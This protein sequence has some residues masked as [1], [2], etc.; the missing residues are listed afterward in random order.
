[1]SHAIR[2]LL[3]FFL[4]VLIVDE[5][6]CCSC[7]A[8]TNDI[9]TQ[10]KWHNLIFSGKLLSVKI[11]KRVENGHIMSDRIYKFLP[12]KVWRGIKADTVII[13]QENSFCSPQL[14]V[15]NA[16]VIYARQHQELSTC[17]RL[18]KNDVEYEAQRL[19]KLFTR[20]LFKQLQAAS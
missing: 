17:S 6:R 5:A 13:N 8:N 20:K 18:I 14:K 3:L 19:D 4:L 16:Y 15:G 12:D 9:K 2:P 11:T 7:S 1:M 10:V